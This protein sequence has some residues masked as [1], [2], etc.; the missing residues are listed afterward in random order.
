[1]ILFKLIAVVAAAASF[2]ALIGCSSPAATTGPGSTSTTSAG[3]GGGLVVQSDSIITAEIKAVRKQSTGYP[4]EVDL[5]IRTSDNV[6]SLPNPTFDKIGQ[7]VTAKSDQDLS[8]FKA[9]QI[10]DARVKY[11]GDVPRPGIQLYA[12]DIKLKQ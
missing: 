3:P 2:I 4:W 10:V 6:G 9:G 5:L 12:Y 1:M 7:V 8:S 11:V